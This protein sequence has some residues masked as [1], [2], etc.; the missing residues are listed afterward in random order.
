MYSKNIRLNSY[1]TTA[2]LKRSNL[3]PLVSAR[4]LKATVRLYPLPSRM[5]IQYLQ[6]EDQLGQRR[7][8]LLSP[9]LPNWTLLHV[10]VAQGL[11]IKTEEAFVIYRSPTDLSSGREPRTA[12]SHL[13]M[14]LLH[15]WVALRITWLEDS[16]NSLNKWKAECVHPCMQAAKVL[17]ITNKFWFAF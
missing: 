9:T 2:E 12:W 14:L 10:P 15:V 5:N 8:S 17:T 16:I 4:R 7:S 3:R 6:G 13:C 11:Q 1:P